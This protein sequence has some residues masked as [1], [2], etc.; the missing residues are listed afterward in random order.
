MLRNNH[1]HNDLLAPDCCTSP[2]PSHWSWTDLRSSISPSHTPATIIMITSYSLKTSPISSFPSLPYSVIKTIKIWHNTHYFFSCLLL[3][4]LHDCT[5]SVP[6]PMT[7]KITQNNNKL[8]YWLFT[9]SHP[10]YCKLPWDIYYANYCWGQLSTQP[11]T[12]SGTRNE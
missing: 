8:I 5:M 6:M 2:K 1:W 9:T 3:Y 10:V 7:I 12:L 11:P 4:N